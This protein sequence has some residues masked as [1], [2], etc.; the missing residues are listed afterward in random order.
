MLAQ[1]QYSWSCHINI[2]SIGPLVFVVLY[3]T[4]NGL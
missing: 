4:Q 2:G 3:I 1:V